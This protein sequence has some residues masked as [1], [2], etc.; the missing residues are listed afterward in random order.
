MKKIIFSLFIVFSAK[1]FASDTVIIDPDLMNKDVWAEPSFLT[2]VEAALL[3][4]QEAEREPAS[5]AESENLEIVQNSSQYLDVLKV[6]PNSE[7]SLSR[8]AVEYK[9]LNQE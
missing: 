1:I 9:I 3:A 4:A 7:P 8:A 5:F 2:G 6:I